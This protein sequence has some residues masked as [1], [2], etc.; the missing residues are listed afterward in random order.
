[1]ASDR[2]VTPEHVLKALMELDRRGSTKILSE[3]EKLEPDLVEH[4]LEDL[5]R[6]FHRLT[7][8]GLSGADARKI[9][10]R[11]EKTVLVCIMALRTA[12]RRLLDDQAGAPEP[13]PEPDD[14]SGSGSPP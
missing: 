5:T 9:Y 6:L 10:H 8:H 13:N 1:M 2:L 11:A 3:L 7:D 12:Y 14:D 4:L